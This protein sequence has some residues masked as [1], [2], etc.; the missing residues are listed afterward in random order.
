[1]T[2][3]I[4]I[5]D[6][7]TFSESDLI[8]NY[9]VTL[10]I[11]SFGSV[12]LGQLKLPDPDS[13]INVAVKITYPKYTDSCPTTERNNSNNPPVAEIISGLSHPNIIKVSYKSNRILL[14]L[15]ELYINFIK[16][17]YGSHLTSKKCFGLVMELADEGDLSRRLQS[18]VELP[19]KSLIAK[20]IIEGLEYL[21]SQ[22]I[23]HRDLEPSNI[24]L[25][26]SQLNPKITGFNHAEVGL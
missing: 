1:M 5:K 19:N 7:V 24:L 6:V 22:N 15:Y 4:N 9:G 26:G 10:G 12:Y 16:Q 3:C 2:Q 14:E 13:Q 18:S 21:H 20:G 8:I 17:I 23:V 11:G 25:F